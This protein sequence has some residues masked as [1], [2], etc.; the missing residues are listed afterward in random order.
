MTIQPNYEAGTIPVITLAMRLRIA[1]EHAGLEQA[2]LA[3]LMDVNR[4]TISRAEVGA[5]EPRRIVLKAWALATGVPLEWILTGAVK[6]ENPSPDGGG[7]VNS[8]PLD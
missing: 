7:S 4:N 1:R 3:R 6:Q 2:D 8:Q 5:S